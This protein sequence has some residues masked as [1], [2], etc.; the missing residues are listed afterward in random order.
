MS[1]AEFGEVW[2]GNIIA[3]E[4][5]EKRATTKLSG[6]VL[7]PVSALVA[8]LSLVGYTFT[9]NI[10]AGILSVTSLI[11]V[12]VC[13]LVNQAEL[14]KQGQLG[15]KIC[16]MG[17]PG[18]S[19]SAVIHS[20]SGKL[21]G[22]VSLVDLSMAYFL[23]VLAI[24][25]ILGFDSSFF[26][27]LALSTIPVLIYSLYTQAVL[28]K[29]WCVLCLTTVA[30]I[31]A[32]DAVA[33]S[34]IGFVFDLVFALKGVSIG[35]VATTAVIVIKKLTDAEARS[36]Q[37]I[38]SLLKLK[39][40]SNVFD[41]LLGQ[42]VVEEACPTSFTFGSQSPKLRI[43]S[44]MSPFC[45]YCKNSY[46]QYS[47]LLRVFGDDIQLNLVFNIHVDDLSSDVAK[48]S[49]T[50]MYLYDKHGSD[51]AWKAM[52]EWY[53]KKSEVEWLGKFGVDDALTAKYL[54]ALEAQKAWCK[55]NKLRYTPL[56][57]IDRKVFP[58]EY[59]LEDLV[60]FVPEMIE[61]SAN[62]ELISGELKP[63]FV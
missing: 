63:E 15:R 37:E 20:A 47:R 27:V 39:R 30:I 43:T 4:E 53:E 49:V 59:N 41:I 54:T 51:Y 21:F 34:N 28:I 42:K 24:S 58:Q 52:G 36:E 50:L 62:R 3:I 6:N 2:S 16:S 19:C 11:G 35:V 33:L 45:G 1:S 60:H 46:H 48:I 25:T 13:Y 23:S 55:S 22:I 9:T 29:Q 44:I 5:P 26:G 38:K 10:L 12:I 31:A 56:T 14:G 7:L 40:N 17:G 32:Q 61:R 18:N 57:M 8:V